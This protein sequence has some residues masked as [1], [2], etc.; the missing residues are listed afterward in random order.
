MWQCFRVLRVK[1]QKANLNTSGGGALVLTQHQ[2]RDTETDSQ[3]NTCNRLDYKF[4]NDYKNIL[5]KGTV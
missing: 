3:R 2:S 4:K 1:H 5:I